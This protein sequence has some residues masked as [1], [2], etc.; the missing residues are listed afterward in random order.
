MAREGLSI[1]IGEVRRIEAGCR[2]KLLHCPEDHR[3]RLALAWCL[4]IEAVH[5]EGRASGTRA[6]VATRGGHPEQPTAAPA[7]PTPPTS[8]LSECLHQTIAV[9]HLSRDPRDRAAVLQISELL[10]LSGCSTAVENAEE[11][12]AAILCEIAEAVLHSV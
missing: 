11:D 2:E 1:D 7:T 6:V 3:E 9:R 10:N 8:L 4:L 12:A 5:E